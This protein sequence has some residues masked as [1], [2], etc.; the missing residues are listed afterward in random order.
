MASST[1]SPP[2]RRSSRKRCVPKRYGF[3]G[4]DK[5]EAKRQRTKDASLR[6]LDL[7]M[8]L[9]RTTVSLLSTV[10]D[11]FSLQSTNK[12]FRSLSNSPEIV[13]AMPLLEESFIQE[14]D[15]AEAVTKRLLPF[16]K[17]HN[18]DAV[19]LLGLLALF[20]EDDTGVGLALL[21]KG[22]DRGDLRCQHEIGNF[23]KLTCRNETD[24]PSGRRLLEEAS[25]AGH[26]PSKVS[27]GI[28]ARGERRAVYQQAREEMVAVSCLRHLM[29]QKDDPPHESWKGQICGGPTCFRRYYNVPLKPVRRWLKAKRHG[30]QYSAY[31]KRVR[32]EIHTW[33]TPF[34][35]FRVNRR[36]LYFVPPFQICSQCQVME[37]C[38]RTC[39]VLHWAEH[40][41]VCRAADANVG[42]PAAENGGQ[43]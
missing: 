19:Y 16:A 1:A 15:T 24:A 21:Q 30:Q 23:L 20:V 27:T 2:S 5:P 41:L 4:Q 43:G 40:K 42:Q 36:S 34:P 28:M 37:Y 6:L 8:E 18:P 9:L 3:E 10:S 32:A 22:M 35:A 13:Q 38:S 14:D 26:A 31:W 29:A 7:P 17:H 33:G 11:R 39:Q 25:T 12:L